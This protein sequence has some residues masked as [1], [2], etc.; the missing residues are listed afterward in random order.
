[1]P[2]APPDR[3]SAKQL[4]VIR[5]LAAARGISDTAGR[6]NMSQ[7]AAS[8]ALSQ[9][10]ASLGV[11][12]FQR[13]WSGTDPTP[14][15]EIVVAASQ[16]ILDDLSAVEAA[17]LGGAGRLAGVIR[18]HQL[19]AVAAVTRS[20]SA[21]GAAQALGIRQ[22]AVSQALRDLSAH[23]PLPLFDRRPA[24][25]AP[26]PAAHALAALWDRIAAELGAI[27]RLIDEAARGVVGRVAVGMLPF[28][29]QDDVLRTFGELT[30]DHPHVRLVAVP[31]SYTALSEA[32][33][34]REIDL[35]IGILRGPS[36]VA[37][38]TETPLYHETFSIVARHD[39]PCH[40]GPMTIEAMA[41]HRWLVGPHGTPPRR[42]F[43]RV[44]R[45]AGAP[46]PAQ[47]CE[48]HGFANAEQMLLES[49]LLGL[50]CYGPAQMA[51]LRAGLRRVA[52]DLPG[53]RVPIG[54]TRPAG[55]A[56]PT[57][58]ATFLSRLE[59]RVSPRV[60]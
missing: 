42:Y 40:D 56:A 30:R 26:T 46:P 60:H 41:R 11:P 13:G 7:S 4:R 12:L 31:G 49:D 21:S 20:G 25:L 28:S 15:G 47:S 33:Q 37:G 59:K 45:R 43:D 32:L 9:A 50:L 10:E 5:A 1:M 55:E 35:I 18:W 22:P 57:A 6:L 14:L 54:V 29:G 2:D 51:G 48:I 3:L 36:P 58:V 34:R 8:R 19:E 16:R 23:V 24:G 17:D 39:H 44:L 38:F 27:P 52:L 53:A